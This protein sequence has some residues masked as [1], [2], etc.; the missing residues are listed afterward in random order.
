MSHT[1][2]VLTPIEARIVAA[3]GQTMYPREGGIPI[4][5]TQARAVEYVDRWLLALPANERVLVRLM[6]ALF[7]VAVPVFA[8]RPT[9]FSRAAPQLRY[10]YLV[11]WETSRFYFR[12]SAMLAL[13]SVFALAYLGSD[14]VLRT[15]GYENGAET[16]ARQR[17]ERGAGPHP[18]E[19]PG[20]DLAGAAN[21]AVLADAVGT[22]REHEHARQTRDSA[23][24]ASAGD[25]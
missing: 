21:V 5:A 8:G 1:L 4:D 3:I 22:V 2:K 12:R 6:F 11:G 7:E 25:N 14:E 24:S 18:A 9:R 19:R 15:I 23:R 13:R 10:D 20:P 17:A 16:L